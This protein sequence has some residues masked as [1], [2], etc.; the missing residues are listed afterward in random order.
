MLNSLLN[1]VELLNSLYSLLQ[2]KYFVGVKM[3]D[4]FRRHFEYQMNENIE[5]SKDPICLSLVV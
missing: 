5:R 3:S 2:Y 4:F 1:S